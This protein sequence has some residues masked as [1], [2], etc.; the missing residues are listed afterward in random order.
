LSLDY[1]LIK[2]LRPCK[3]L[4]D[5]EENKSVGAAG[6]RKLA[7][8]VFPSARWDSPTHG[9][10][11]TELDSIE[12][13]VSGAALHLN[14]RGKGN[15][16]AVMSHIAAAAAPSG[17]ALVDVQCSDFFLPEE[18]KS[19]GYLEWYNNILAGYSG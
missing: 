8:R 14:W 7:D 1:L 19:A 6:Y 3:S 18:A 4:I 5:V 16:V 9:F 13:T 10:Q 17:F 11:M 15:V 12:L 2:P